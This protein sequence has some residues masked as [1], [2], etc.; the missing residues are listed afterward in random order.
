MHVQIELT[1]TT[2]AQFRCKQHDR[3]ARDLQDYHVYGYPYKL[4]WYPYLVG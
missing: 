1:K 4:N 2:C 3:P